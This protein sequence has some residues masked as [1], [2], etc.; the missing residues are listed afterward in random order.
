MVSPCRPSSGLNYAKNYVNTVDKS[1]V[2]RNMVST[3]SFVQVIRIARSSFRNSKTLVENFIK[4]FSFII[5]CVLRPFLILTFRNLDFRLAQYNTCP[6]RVLSYTETRSDRT[7]WH[8]LEGC[9]I[10]SRHYWPAC[11]NQPYGLVE[12]KSRETKV[13]FALLLLLPLQFLLGVLGR[14]SCQIADTCIVSG[15]KKQQ[16]VLFGENICS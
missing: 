2:R 14:P 1:P 16:L 13:Y 5:N 7:R 12:S 11:F 9:K 3:F 10:K 8:I 4:P 15:V 6:T